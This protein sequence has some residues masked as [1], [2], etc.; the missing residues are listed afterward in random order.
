MA[1]KESD[2]RKQFGVSKAPIP[3]TRAFSKKMAHFEEKGIDND[4]WMLLNDKDG[5]R[6][7]VNVFR[8]RAGAG[9]KAQPKP[10]PTAEKDLARLL[11]GYTQRPVGECPVAVEV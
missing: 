2:L 9:F 11:K 1:T 7:S 5:T 3:T 6:V 8:G 10:I 4:A